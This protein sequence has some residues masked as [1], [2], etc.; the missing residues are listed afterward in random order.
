MK[1]IF[2]I[3]FSF[4]GL[5]ITSPL[6]I[7][8]LF[9][10]WLEDKR[11]PFYV[12]NRIGKRGKEFKMIKI[13]TMVVDADANNVDSTSSD[14][15]RITKIGFWL[16]R[17]RLDELPQLLAVLKGDMSLIGPRPERPE[18]DEILTKEIPNYKLRYL[19]RPGLSG[20]AQVSYPYGA[21]IEDTK[22]KFS[23]D[24]YYIK[25]FSTFFDFLILLETVRLV[26]NFRGSQPK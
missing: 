2:D 23:Y 24:M 12:S 5:F 14:D 16:R 21:S 10:V 25:N 8:I 9:F 15:K 6:M 20:W 13:R 11:S 17:T 4:S 18:L 22:M 7:I 3:F 19:V 1:R 26:F